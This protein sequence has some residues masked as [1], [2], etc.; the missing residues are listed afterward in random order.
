M[1]NG[2]SGLGNLPP[3]FGGG[4]KKDQKK[5]V[6]FGGGGRRGSARGRGRARVRAA[7]A[8]AR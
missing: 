6:R 3:G 5:S 2:P 8:R 1:G 7:A 4:D